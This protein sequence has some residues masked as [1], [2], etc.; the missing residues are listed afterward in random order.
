MTTAARVYLLL[1]AAAIGVYVAIGGSDLLYESFSSAGFCAVVFGILKNRPK[2]PLGWIV[3]AVATLCQ[4][5]ADI[6]YFSVYDAS[7]PFPSVADALYLASALL[8]GAALLILAQSRLHFREDPMALVDA[9]VLSLAVALLLWAS[10][11]GGALGTG[12][13]VARAWSIAYP[14]IDM[15]L[16]A[17]LVRVLLENGRRTASYYLLGTSVVLLVL[18]DAWYVLPALTD[19]YVA[20][21]W[22]DAGWLGSYV[23]AGAAALDPSMRLFVRRERRVIPTRRVL[24][25]GTSMVAVAWAAVLQEY[26]NGNADLYAFGGC[27]GIMAIF[28]TVRVL[29]LVRQVEHER[30]RAQESERRFRMIF[31]RSPIG[32]SVGRDG[33]MSETN[34]A[35]QRMLGYTGEE[36]AEKHYLDVTHPDDAAIGPQTQLDLGERDAVSFD[37][38]YVARDGRVVDAHVHVALD[39]E[40]GLGIS[41]VED[42]TER[43]ELE[44][45]LRQAQKMEAVGKLAG[46]VA[47]D[48][49][50]LMTAV[51]GYSDLTLKRL[52][53]A[54]VNRERVEAIRGAAERASDLTRQLLAFSRRQV[55]QTTDVDLRDVVDELDPLLRRVIGEDVL[56]ETLFGPEPVLVRADRTQ[57]EQVVM[58]LVVN[59]REAMPAGGLLTIAVGSDDEHALLTVSDTGAGMAEAVVAHIFEPFFTTKGLASGTGLG[60]ATVHGIVGQSG[61]TIEVQTEVGEG[62]TFAIRLP[63]VGRAMLLTD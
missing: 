32:I 28:I 60:L 14:V 11:F 57:L 38:R 15:L 22:R 47:H 4:A 12:T 21:T 37:K 26:L 25:L 30:K 58:N 51:L 62:T 27:G 3:F 34:P 49:N 8:V 35:L 40:D 9:C 16:L 44:Q 23:A 42:V 61:G 2:K 54:D 13:G 36:L 7:P 33:V 59:A 53:P 18:S 43:R 24:L 17:V 20:G 46:G 6:L 41:L 39:V 55:L 50:N 1:G 52:A 56:F 31:E 10:F 48:F 19:H 29:G 5:V 63:L 45:Q